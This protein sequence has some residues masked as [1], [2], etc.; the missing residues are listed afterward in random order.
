MRCRDIVKGLLD[1]A[2]QTPPRRQPADLNEVARRS[3]AV[4]MNQLALERVALTLD[5]EA[6]LPKVSVDANQMQQVIL[7]L[8]LNAADAVGAAGG[9]IRL[10]SRRIDLPP[11]GNEPIRK[12]FCPNGCDLLEPTVK[13]RGLSAIRVLKSCGGR[14]ATMDLDPIYGRPSHMAADWFD[15]G[16]DAVF[17]CSRCRTSLQQ[18]DRRCR[19]CGAATFAVQTS[20]GD[21]IFW[22]AR[23]GC[24]WTFWESREAAGPQPVMELVVEDTGC[25]ISVEDQQHLFEPFFSTKGHHGTGLGLAVTWGIVESHGGTIDVVSE[26]GKG[27]R[28]TVR[29][30]L[31]GAPAPRERPAPEVSHA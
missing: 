7:N 25:G 15:G 22:C 6:D 4:V 14:V 13:I 16:V 17:S 18:P 9:T 23:N 26:P 1:F 24:H 27:S 8:L 5:L 11:L 20:P 29:L 28:F 21:R 31:A 10:A 2:R 30:P 12:A 3:V 19:A